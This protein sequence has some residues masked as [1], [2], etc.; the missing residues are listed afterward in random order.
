MRDAGNS[1][2]EQPSG[3]SDVTVLKH[4]VVDNKSLEL[5]ATDVAVSLATRFQKPIEPF[6]VEVIAYR[7]KL[8]EDLSEVSMR[9]R[10]KFSHAGTILERHARNIVPEIPA[11]SGWARK[12]IAEMIREYWQA[13]GGEHLVKPKKNGI[14]VVRN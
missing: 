13:G 5:L 10:V 7:R 11:T 14:H 2:E 3:R 8:G 1:P 4:I 6:A 12:H 9:T